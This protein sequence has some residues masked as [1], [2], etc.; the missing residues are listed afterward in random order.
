MSEDYKFGLSDLDIADDLDVSLDNDTY[1]DQAN[2]APPAYGDYLM[3]LLS[4]DGA[5]RKNSISPATYRGGDNKG[6]PVF[7][8]FNEVKYPVLQIGV[9]EIVDGLGEGITRKVGLFQEINTSSYE[10]EGKNVS[11]L[12]D[13]ARALGLSNFSGVKEALLLLEEA[14]QNGA[15]FGGTLDWVSGYDKAFVEAAL[16]QL[17]L[18]GVE[19]ASY[20]DEQK[21]LSRAIYRNANVV[22]MRNFPFNPNTGRFSHIAQRGNVTFTD[23][24]TKQK[25]TVE[26]AQR[27]L[28]EARA[29]LVVGAYGSHYN[30]IKFISRER[31]D[32]GRVV[33]G[34]KAVRPATAAA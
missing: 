7:R 18:K 20:T 26:V 11:Q 25:V 12:G 1:Q 24:N 13:F 19:K 8:T 5:G 17:G 10:R 32:S 23:P 2:P 29:Q 21:K 6:Q 34:P 14:Q 27:A 31:V 4:A 9:V 22:G 30:D 28:G 15:T 33:F 16:E 3:K